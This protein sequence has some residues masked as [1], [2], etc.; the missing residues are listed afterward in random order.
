LILIKTKKL[1]NAV[2]QD[3]KKAPKNEFLPYKNEKMQ[4]FGFF[5]QKPK[6][7]TN[8]INIAI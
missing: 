6:G 1:L 8:T 7:K 5:W 3:F 4:N 2:D